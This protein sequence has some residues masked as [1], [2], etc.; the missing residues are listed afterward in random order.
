MFFKSIEQHLVGMNLNIVI[1][2]SET[3]L[4]VS[5]LPQ[6]TCKD[7]AKKNITPILLKGTADELDAQFAGIIQQPLQKVSG[8]STN[9]IQFER[10]VEKTE[11]DNAITKA[12]KDESKKLTD[13]ADKLLDEAEKLIKEDKIS[14]AI[15][16]IEGALKIA[17]EYKKA[18]DLLAK[19]KPVSTTDIFA[20]VE[21]VKLAPKNPM[22]I[23]EAVA[24]ADVVVEVEVN[25]NLPPNSLQEVNP[26]TGEKIGEP[27][28]LESTLKN[29]VILGAESKEEEDAVREALKELEQPITLQEVADASPN[30]EIVSIPKVEEI[31][32]APDVKQI[33]KDNN[34][35]SLKGTPKPKRMDMES[36]ENY[37]IRLNSWLVF[38]PEQ[39]VEN[40]AALIPSAIPIEEIKS[41]M[42]EMAEEDFASREAAF[43]ADRVVQPEVKEEPISPSSSH[44]EVLG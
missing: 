32:V 1:S 15:L 21:E 35:V 2:K 23:A 14:A 13:K 43:E 16:K 12:K 41:P 10:A 30:V 4:V 5:V 22:T 17:P 3:G 42:Q 26:H 18:L 20:V 19:H 38:N 44:I 9:L 34:P 39:I 28:V 7:E 37:T 27:V 40:P 8:L 25:L 24:P 11:A 33:D 6:L 31:V 29:P 36:M